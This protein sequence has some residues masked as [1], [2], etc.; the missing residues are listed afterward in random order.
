M[1]AIAG[2]KGGCGKTTVTIG[3][4]AALAERGIPVLAVDADRQLP[5][6]HTTVDVDREPTIAAL[7]GDTDVSKVAKQPSS[8]PGVGVITAQQPSE[9][10]DFEAAIDR[11][12]Y[13]SAAVLIDC[14]S[15][16]GPDVVEPVAAAD[17][18]VVVTTGTD[19]SLEAARTTLDIAHRLD[20]PVAGVVFNRCASVPSDRAGEFEADVIG[21]VP[22]S[23]RPLSETVITEAY[24]PIASALVGDTGISTTGEEI[25]R[26]PDRLPTGIDSLDRLLDGGVVR[27]SV[28]ALEAD[29]ASQ[30]ELLLHNATAARGTLYLTTERS[31]VA[32][33]NALKTSPV[34]VGSPT[35]RRLD[36]DAPL[37]KATSLIE[38]LPDG[39]TLVIDAVNPLEATRRA[40]YA[41]F[42]N[43]VTERTIEAGGLALL[44]CLEEPGEGHRT[45]TEQFADVVVEYQPPSDGGEASLRLLKC[46]AEQTVGRTEHV[47][48]AE[49]VPIAP[50]TTDA[51]ADDSG[52]GRSKESDAAG[53]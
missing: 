1:I 39:A 40:D 26:R 7:D 51:A 49:A 24:A 32:V 8:L 23:E 17:H 42:L 29:P 22:D 19:R 15:G 41:D 30:A 43:A 50:E 12:D 28:L 11:L 34:T 27:G 3:L 16:A 2:A 48:L 35:I 38:N 10:V 14:P 44:H 18:V 9:T 4:A 13:E 20:V 53:Q 31:E 6:L 21:A 52:D 46:R 36:G 5:D 33:R 25:P 45:L 37:G 47:A